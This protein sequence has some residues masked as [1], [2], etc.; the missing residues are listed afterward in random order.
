MIDFQE[1]QNIDD[2]SL[3]II[4]QEI[5]SIMEDRKI[6]AEKMEQNEM[7]QSLQDLYKSFVKVNNVWCNLRDPEFLD[8]DYPFRTSF[9]ELVLKVDRWANSVSQH[10]ENFNG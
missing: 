6:E 4:K 8:N 2:N 9:D 7:A 10:V 5:D 3:R 1:L